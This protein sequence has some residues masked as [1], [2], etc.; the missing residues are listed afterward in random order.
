MLDRV[1]ALK[2]LLTGNIANAKAVLDAYKDFVNIRSKYD[3]IRLDNLNK[4]TQKV[5]PTQFNKSIL[6]AYYLKG[7]KVYS[8]LKN[9]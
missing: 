5:I 9:F 7:K 8:T 3:S 2:F 6:S 4:T 1:A